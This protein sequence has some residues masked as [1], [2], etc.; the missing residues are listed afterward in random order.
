M[1]LSKRRSL[2][3][4]SQSTKLPGYLFKCVCDCCGDTYYIHSSIRDL[5]DSGRCVSCDSEIAWLE[6]HYGATAK[7]STR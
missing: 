1:S 5:V 7:V 2:P 4:K 6:S 3:L